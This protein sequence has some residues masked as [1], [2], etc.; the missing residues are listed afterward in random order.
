MSI[1]PNDLAKYIREDDDGIPLGD[2]LRALSKDIETDAVGD[3]RD[4]RERT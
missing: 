3:V 4:I 1:T 2:A